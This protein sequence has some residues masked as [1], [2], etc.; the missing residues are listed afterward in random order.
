MRCLLLKPKLTKCMKNYTFNLY[1]TRRIKNKL[2][3]T[4]KITVL[5]IISAF[6]QVSAASFA[7][8]N[9]SLSEKNSSLKEV[10]KSIEA[11]SGYSVF[12]IQKMIDKALPVT[13]DVKDVPLKEAL[14]QCFEHQPLSYSIRANTIVI[15][16]KEQKII[17]ASISSNVQDV[18]GTVTDENGLGIPGAN[19]RIKGTDRGAVTDSSG[20]FKLTNVTEGAVLVISYVG[21]FTQEVNIGSNNKITVKMEVQ[22]SD[23]TEVVVVG[24]GAQKKANLS[25][26][27]ATITSSQ[28]KD[29]PVTSMQ[30][31]LQGLTPG[32]TIIQRP[33]DVTSVGTVTLRG[34]T[35]LGSASP[36]YIIDGIPA[37][38][39][40][41]ASLNPNDVESISVLKD[42]AAASIYGSRAANG[43]LVINTKR[44]KGEDKGT[45]EFNTTYGLQSPTRLPKYTNAT[46]Y[47]T[48][49]NEALTNA[50]RAA[51]YT[52]EQIQK[53]G[54]G[55]DPDNYANTDWY[56]LALRKN[57]AQSNSTISISSA[58]KATN[59][60]LSASYLNQ[61]SL[62]PNKDQNRY[63]LNLNADTRVN[64]ILKLGTNISYYRQNYDIAGGDLNWVS[65]NRLTP[66]L[67]ARQSD[68]SWGTIA[69]GALS[70]TLAADNVL[71]RMEE[72]GKSYNRNNYLQTAAT[73]VLTPVKGLSINGLASLKTTNTNSWAFT[74]TMSPLINFLTKAPITSTAVTVNE[75]KEKWGKTQNFLI[76]GYADYEYKT[77][78]HAAKIMVGAS[79]ES[80][81]A[82]SAYLGRKNFPNNEMTTIVS[83]SSATE[84]VSTLTDDLNQSILGNSTSDLEWAMR[85]FFGRFN[86]NFN[87]KYLLEA[88][89]RMDYSSRFHPDVRRAIFP[90]F[91][92]AW[93]LSQEGFMKNVTWI[94]DLKLRGSWGMLG[95]QDA[96]PLGNYFSLLKSGYSYSF[97][98]TP[99]D[100]VWQAAGVEPSATWEKVRMSNF[101]LDFSLLKGKLTVNAD[102]YIK[103]ST[104]ILIQRNA[105]APYALTPPARNSGSVKN[106]GLELNLS[107]SDVIGKDF[108]Y[109]IG[110]NLSK[111][112]NKIT[113]LGGD[114][115]R[116]TGT[117]FIEKLG[118][119]VGSFYGYEAEGLFVDAADVAAHAFQSA[120]T[121][122]GDIKYK[123]LN[124]DKKIDAADR[125]V[126]G[127]DVPF[128]NYGLSLNLA[129][130][131]F[132][133]EVLT[134]GVAGVKT[135]LESEAGSPFFNSAGVKEAFKNR[136]TKENPDPNADFP[137]LLRSQDGPQ[138]AQISSFWLF[139]GSYFRVR[140]LTLGYS[141]PALLTQKL[142]AQGI[143]FYI[144]A[145]NPFTYMADKRLADYDPE[146]GSG[147]G[148]N[149]PGL[150]TWS[151]GANI[152]F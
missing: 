96:V 18:T 6:M 20:Q 60:Y 136:W 132:N 44:G 2:F 137:R 28:L 42:A 68:G 117:Y 135:Y 70:T 27:V 133:L 148:G 119:S 64:S 31:A 93:R 131:N 78:Q 149:G 90:S 130:K 30:N 83:G 8:K 89:L 124:G 112:N 67:A 81:I 145:N 49:L 103:N 46:D 88:N 35:N 92:A 16:E 34:R 55:S 150:K 91:S 94:N 41:F 72:S 17:K 21:Y 95:N 73:A 51:L 99:Y 139:S 120:A 45:V 7:Q 109:S 38:S 86:Y 98:G 126:I 71:R 140:G 53:F 61:E 24:Y 29:R 65:L 115:N 106:T 32:L 13:I 54:N 108:R 141:L 77:E 129:Y 142:K 118:E 23:L 134:Y 59:Y 10:L 147:R 5:L 85:S 33:G 121:G 105:L 12:F 82:R 97:D 3:V 125:K 36:M 47:A 87:D 9:I 107:Y 11:Q 123:D 39:T 40:Q 66:V 62:V 116:I 146:T 79:Q 63:T 50:G 75:L 122:P 110:A 111:I 25:G 113:G 100:G 15:K 80:N 1:G 43:V 84:D 26:S 151:I 76:Q 152:K 48:L 37:T 138:N 114:N 104:D 58:G 101:G 22:P 14:D 74:N 69:G 19:V 128:L 102:Y 52:P 144:T 143:R 127:N 56:K 4:L 57:P